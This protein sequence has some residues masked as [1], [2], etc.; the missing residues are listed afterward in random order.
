MSAAG[1]WWVEGHLPRKIASVLDRREY[2][3]YSVCQWKGHCC[4]CK[5]T[6]SKWSRQRNCELCS[7][8]AQ[9]SVCEQSSSGGHVIGFIR[10]HQLINGRVEWREDDPTSTQCLPDADN[11]KGFM[12]V[13]YCLSRD[14]MSIQFGFVAIN[15]ELVIE[16]KRKT[17]QQWKDVFMSEYIAL[18][19]MINTAQYILWMQPFQ[20]GS[21]SPHA[22]AYSKV[23]LRAILWKQK[24]SISIWPSTVKHILL[25]KVSLIYIFIQKQ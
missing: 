23:R 24:M 13:H 20:K 15:N 19:D 21:F 10:R 6:A 14:C 5:L 16:T 8:K 17:G 3:A 4:H 18:D 25:Q 22:H 2:E 9:L 7:H 12:V 1:Q 11:N